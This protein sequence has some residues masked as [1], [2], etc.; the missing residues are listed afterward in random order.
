[1]KVL[2]AISSEKL[3][4][5]E[6]RWYTQQEDTVTLTRSLGKLVEWIK[7]MKSE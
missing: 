7:Q 4:C 2:P 5:H 3:T 1:M 6:N